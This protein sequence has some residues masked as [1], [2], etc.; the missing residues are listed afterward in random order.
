MNHALNKP[1]IGI[2]SSLLTINQGSFIGRERTFVGYDYV[3]SVV[4]TG[5]VP[6]VLPV[7][8]EEELI[9]DQ[10]KM[11]DGLLLSGGYDVNPQFYGE[12]PAQG[13]ETVNQERDLHEMQLAR[14][15]YQA[16]KPI[17]GICRG[18]QL[19]NV[20]FG[21]SLYQDIYSAIPHALQHDQKMKPQMG[22]HQVNVVENTLLHQ[23]VD[24]KQLLTNS[25]HHQAIK[26]LAPTF[27][28][29]ARSK[30]GLIEG[31]EKKDHPFIL[32]VQ[33]HPELMFNHSLPMLKLFEA[34]V[35][36]AVKRKERS[37]GS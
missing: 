28:V 36:A 8:T 18:L 16:G 2:S 5:G 32:A 29:N 22:T 34:F 4:S 17:F 15:A 1:F 35:Q 31:I 7:V 27:I 21:G 3:Q 11:M 6:F 20:V 9:Y 24:Q 10:I 37:N 33:W 14:L 13:L 23:I 26:T 30:D 25:Y 19:L 12:E